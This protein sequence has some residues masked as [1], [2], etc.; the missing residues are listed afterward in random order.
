[1]DTT[2]ALEN[3]TDLLLQANNRYNKIVERLDSL[4]N[5][6]LGTARAAALESRIQELEDDFTAS[7]LQL[8]DSNALLAL[9]N[10]AHTKINQLVDGT[11]P[12]ELQYNTDVIF[13][14]RGTT[15]DKSI[16]GK[17]KVNNDVDGYAVSDVYQWDIASQITTGALTP[18]TPFD[19]SLANQ[20]GVWAKLNA[21][22]NRLSLN[23][24]LNQEVLNSNL[25]IYID[26]STTGWKKGQVFKV[27]IDTIDV[28]GN[29]INILTNKSGGFNTTIT[30]I[31]PSQLLT[32]KPYFEIVCIDPV[33]Y[34]FEVDILR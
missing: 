29:N 7:S 8:Q 27:A 4:E 19:N 32:N 1:M 16:A 3:A 11:I 22:S 28:D 31:A 10:N 6:I 18:T 30:T 17:I 15:V 5:V 9:I 2:T 25:N 34:V 13:S 21:Y 23:N 14:G 20:Y 33:N 24:L 26:D 12:V